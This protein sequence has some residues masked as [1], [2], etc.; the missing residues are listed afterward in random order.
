MSDIFQFVSAYPLHQTKHPQAKNV[1]LLLAL[2]I[3]VQ[4]PLEVKLVI[5]F[6]EAPHDILIDQVRVDFIVLKKFVQI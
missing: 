1:I 4:S 3:F 2:H 6:E 5:R